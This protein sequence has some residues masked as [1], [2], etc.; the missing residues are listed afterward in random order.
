M[1]DENV[2]VALDRPESIKLHENYKE[3]IGQGFFIGRDSPVQRIFV[4]SSDHFPK[5]NQITGQLSIPY[6]DK[7]IKN[8]KSE[9]NRYIKNFLKPE[10]KSGLLLVSGALQ[11]T[12][13]KLFEPAGS[14]PLIDYGIRFDESSQDYTQLPVKFHVSIV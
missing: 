11:K 3:D 14:E 6:M 7:Q 10:L 1:L 12:E 13:Q 2:F 8:I 4:P 5:S 9:T